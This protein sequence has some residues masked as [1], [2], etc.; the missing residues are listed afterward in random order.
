MN[1]AERLVEIYYRQKRCFTI[2]DIKVPMGNNRQLDLLVID[3]N[4]GNYYHVETSVTNDE[5]WSPTFEWLTDWTRYKFFGRT[6]STS[7]SRGDNYELCKTY[8][9]AMVNTYRDFHLDYNSIIRVWCVWSIRG[10]S[11]DGYTAWREYMASTYKLDPSRFEILSMRDMI[12]PT[13]IANVEK[14]NYTDD[15]IRCISLL[16]AGGKFNAI[17]AI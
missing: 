14:S 16:G 6:R 2:T 9:N 1:A 15:L 13:I 4:S 11:D 12:L 10:W 5:K 8:L 17:K 7:R 3:N